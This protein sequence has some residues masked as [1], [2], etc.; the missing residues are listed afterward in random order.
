MP[1]GIT[2]FDQT[3]TRVQQVQLNS[4]SAQL[5]SNVVRMLGKTVLALWKAS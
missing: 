2:I 1:L 3:A 5:A 4:G